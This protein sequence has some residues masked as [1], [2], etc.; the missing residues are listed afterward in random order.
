MEAAHPSKTSVS[1]YK[2]MQGH[3]P[4]DQSQ[5]SPSWI[6]GNLYLPFYSSHQHWAALA[7]HNNDEDLFTVNIGLLAD[8]LYL[9]NI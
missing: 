2:T 3:N 1:T 9:M 4:E 7:L 5:Q 8:G 6:Y